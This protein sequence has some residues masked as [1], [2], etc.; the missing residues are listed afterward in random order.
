MLAGGREPFW[1]GFYRERK[2]KRTLGE[3]IEGI[4]D[5][6]WGWCFSGSRQETVAILALRIRL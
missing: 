3:F 1:V 4:L 5:P 2:R 6:V